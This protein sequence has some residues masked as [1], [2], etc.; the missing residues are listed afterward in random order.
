MKKN[1]NAFTRLAGLMLLSC[2]LLTL[3]VIASGGAGTSSDPLVTLSYL[4][5]KF[6]PQVLSET[7]KKIAERDKT[8][9]GKLTE[10][11]KTDAAEFERKY[12]TSTGTTG[13]GTALSFEVITLDKGKTLTCDIGCEVM[14][15]VGSA[16][17]T[18]SSN[19]GLVDETGGTTIANG[20]ALQKNHLYMATITGSGVKAGANGTKLLIR[21]GYTLGH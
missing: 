4:N 15:R 3:S 8:L 9:S 17:C 21:G 5:E 18:A 2:M 6:L 11:I 20:G 7:D 13:A 1:H 14:L 16:S 10:Q 19:P 12:G